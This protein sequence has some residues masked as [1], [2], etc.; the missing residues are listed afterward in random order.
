MPDFFVPID[1]TQYTDYHRNLVAKGVVIKATTGYI[2]K[3]RKELQN[4]YKKFEAFNE[5]FEID[6][7]FLAEIRTLADKENNQSLPLIKTQLKALIA[8][9][10]WDMNEYFQVMNSTNQSVQQALKVLNEGI[11]STIIQ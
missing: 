9:D 5:K 6:D 8:R 1:T 4:K 3:H 10:L 2:E 7:N 11:Y